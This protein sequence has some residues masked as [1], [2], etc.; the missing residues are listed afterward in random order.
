MIVHKTNQSKGLGLFL[1][2]RTLQHFGSLWTSVS[3]R[4]V[5]SFPGVQAMQGQD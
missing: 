5:T 4:R 1:P 2:E 3:P